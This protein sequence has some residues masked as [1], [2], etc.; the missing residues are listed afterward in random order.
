MKVVDMFGVGVPVAA[1]DFEALPELVKNKENG[2][3]VRDGEELGTLLT[4]LF[5]PS[6][7]EELLQLKKGAEK[8]TERRWDEN[9]DKVAAPVF[10]FDG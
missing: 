2:V 10:G 1:V 6:K 9:W 4:D 7:P 5:N 3:V 8:E